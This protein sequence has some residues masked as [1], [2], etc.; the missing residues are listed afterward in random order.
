MQTGQEEGA[1]GVLL[2]MLS[3]FEGGSR[4]E[5]RAP[6]RRRRIALLATFDPL[7]LRARRLRCRQLSAFGR[8]LGSPQAGRC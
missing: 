5:V 6:G 4:K 3:V 7:N 2:R 8:R 1:D